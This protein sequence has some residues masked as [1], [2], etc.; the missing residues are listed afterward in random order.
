[1]KKN[2]TAILL[3]AALPMAAPPAVSASA[4]APHAPN[5][6]WR[7]AGDMTEACT[8]QVPCTCQFGQGSSPTPHCA[9]VSTFSVNEGTYGGASLAGGKF[10]IIFG[11]KK[12]VLY[13]DGRDDAQRS[14]LRGVLE[15]ISRKSGWKDVAIRESPIYQSLDAD[16]EK[17]SIGELSAMEAAML[18]GFDGK[19]PIVVEN[20]NDFNVPRIEKA[21]TTSLKYRDDLG[22]IIDAK[23]SNAGRGHFDWTDRTVEYVH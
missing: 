6:S 5:V 1:M 18:K 8:C 12:T 10:A 14:A 15:E 3:L 2:F 4:E 11:P 19:S 22:N 9:S 23:D 20:N 16:I 7:V 21:K 13:I 17:S